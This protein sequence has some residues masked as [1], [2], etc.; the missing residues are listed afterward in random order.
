MTFRK[1]KVATQAHVLSYTGKEEEQE[2]M[3]ENPGE[4]TEMKAPDYRY[5]PKHEYH[6]THEP[7]EDKPNSIS[8]VHHFGPWQP[9]GLK[10]PH[11]PNLVYINDYHEHSSP[12]YKLRPEGGSYYEDYTVLDHI[13]AMHPSK[14]VY[15]PNEYSAV[16]EEQQEIEDMRLQMKTQEI[17]RLI[18]RYS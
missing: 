3:F 14:R 7:I 11:Y 2:D 12:I 13:N 18:Q 1:R 5:W 8:H 16:R 15:H 6:V 4:L 10:E 17:E 9:L